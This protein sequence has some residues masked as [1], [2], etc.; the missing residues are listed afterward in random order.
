MKLLV[1]CL[2]KLITVTIARYNLLPNM[3]YVY[4]K[5]DTHVI[6]V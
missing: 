3:P 6:H 2:R 1:V 4:H 5:C